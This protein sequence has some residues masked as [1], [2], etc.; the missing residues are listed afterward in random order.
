MMLSFIVQPLLSVAVTI[1]L[2]SPVDVV[3][4]VV[5][6]AVASAMSVDGDHKY[7]IGPFEEVAITDRLA[8]PPL[9]ILVSFDVAMCRSFVGII[10]EISLVVVFPQA[11]STVT[12]T[13]M[14]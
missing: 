6:S 11:S 3:V 4:T 7:E 9:Q 1:Y 5:V 8:V 2:F 13:W 10:I 14:F 12:D